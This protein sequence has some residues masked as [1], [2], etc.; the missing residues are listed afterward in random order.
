MTRLQEVIARAI[1]RLGRPAHAWH[2]CTVR[3][4]L[5]AWEEGARQSAELYWACTEQ[6]L[7]R[8]IAIVAAPC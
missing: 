8:R 1:V 5:A 6:D 4:L 7:N 2:G 3:E